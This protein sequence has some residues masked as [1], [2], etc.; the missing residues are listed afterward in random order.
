MRDK[1][2]NSDVVVREEGERE[3]GVRR[4][5]SVSQSE[6]LYQSISICISLYQSRHVCIS[7]LMTVSIQTCLYQSRQVCISP[8]MSVSVQTCQ[9]MSVSLYECHLS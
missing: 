8:D 5:V 3:G 6:G 2:G 4:S 9:Y 7:P 1:G